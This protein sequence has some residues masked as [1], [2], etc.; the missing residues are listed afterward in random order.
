MRDRT[1]ADTCEARRLA[2]AQEFLPFSLAE[3][4]DQRLG[5]E[6]RLDGGQGREARRLEKVEDEVIEVAFADAPGVGL[7]ETVHVG[8]E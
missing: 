4:F 3:T 2:G 8:R 7:P 1:A 5:A 6:G